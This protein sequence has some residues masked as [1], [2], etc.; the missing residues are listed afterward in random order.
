MENQ[1]EKLE[2]QIESLKEQLALAS[3]FTDPQ[4]TKERI[5]DMFYK[6]SYNDEIIRAIL[7]MIDRSIAD[8]V[9]QTSNQDIRNDDR[10]HGLGGVFWLSSLASDIQGYLKIARAK[11]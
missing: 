3:A 4:W 1:I 6:Y 11:K 2:K 10:I 5:A 8:I 7:A 9:M